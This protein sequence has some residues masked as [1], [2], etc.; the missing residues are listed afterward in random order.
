MSEAHCTVSEK[1]ISQSQFALRFVD[2][3]KNQ[4]LFVCVE[5]TAKIE[6]M[7]LSQLLSCSLARQLDR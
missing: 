6:D 1:E 3:F 7:E 4:L 2:L 5:S